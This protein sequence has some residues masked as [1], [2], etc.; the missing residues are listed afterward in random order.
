MQTV[1]IS[2]T[3]CYSY[4]LPDRPTVQD[5]DDLVASLPS[6]T[7]NQSYSV[8]VPRTMIPYLNDVPDFCEK[9]VTDPNDCE[10]GAWGPLRFFAYPD[11]IID[12]GWHENLR[13][14]E[15]S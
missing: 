8:V 7:D 14:L 11:V 13:P 6:Y 12:K 4:L 9:D 15:P 10:I 5:F 1:M 2:Y 3:R